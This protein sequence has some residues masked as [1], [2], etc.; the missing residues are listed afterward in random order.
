MINRIF[1]FFSNHLTFNKAEQTHSQNVSAKNILNS[2]IEQYNSYNLI[3]SDSDLSNDHLEFILNDTK[4]ISNVIGTT[5]LNEHLNRLESFIEKKDFKSF[6][7]ELRRFTDI[8]N[9]HKLPLDIQ[10]EFLYFLGIL[11]IEK[12]DLALAEQMEKRLE[13]SNNRFRYNKLRLSIIAAR[14][15]VSAFEKYIAEYE[16]EGHNPE[17]I[18]LDRAF[19]YLN[20]NDFTKVINTLFI[21]SSVIKSLQENEKYNLYLGLAFFYLQEID[22]A[23]TFLNKSYTIKPNSYKQLILL[24]NSLNKI[25]NLKLNRDFINKKHTD[26]LINASNNLFKL[27]SDILS[28]N[29]NV[30]LIYFQYLLTVLLYVN[31]QKVKMVLEEIP[32]EL[33]EYRVFDYYLA[34]MYLIQFDFEKALS[35]Y[36]ILPI[37]YYSPELEEKK[38]YCMY[39]LKQYAKIILEFEDNIVKDFSTHY[40]GIYEIYLRSLYYNSDTEIAER[41]HNLNTP[42]LENWIYYLMLGNLLN[43][44]SYFEGLE[45]L[46]AE[47]DPQT[48]LYIARTFIE[49]KQFDRA[50]EFLKSLE[51]HRIEESLIIEIELALNL[52][53][54]IEELQEYIHILS[55]TSILS[56]SLTKQKLL[57]YLYFDCENYFD[58]TLLLEEIWNNNQQEQN[59]ENA[60]RI[61]IGKLINTDSYS[62]DKYLAVLESSNHPHYL[63]ICAL[64]YKKFKKN[65]LYCFTLL[66]KSLMILDNKFDQIIYED[67]ISLFIPLNGPPICDF[68]NLNE[69]PEK[70]ET[71]CK[72]TLKNST[73]EKIFN[74]YIY[75]NEADIPLL[76]ES[77]DMHI[78]LNSL[79]WLTLRNRKKGELFSFPTDAN[80]FEIIAI[81]NK[82]L[83]LFQYCLASCEKENSSI[84]TFKT[85]ADNITELIEFMKDTLPNPNDYLEL[86]DKYLNGEIPLVV[87]A[88]LNYDKL[89][90]VL[91]LLSN[92]F[93]YKIMAGENNN[94]TTENVVFSISSLILLASK[95][96]IPHLR[97]D[98]HSIYITKSTQVFI[99]RKFN[100]L[101][102]IQEP[103]KTI[104]LNEEGKLCL[105]EGDINEHRK[106]LEL[107]RSLILFTKNPLVKVVQPQKIIEKDLKEFNLDIDPLNLA[108]QLEATYISE[109]F[110]IKRLETTL[111]V[112]NMAG[113]IDLMFV[114][115]QLSYNHYISLLKELNLQ[116]YETFNSTHQLNILTEYLL[117]TR[118]LYYKISP[119][120]S[121]YQQILKLYL[122]RANHLFNKFAILKYLIILIR[123][124]ENKKNALPIISVIFDLLREISF[125]HFGNAKLLVTVMITSFNKSN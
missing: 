76:K 22:Q 56:D 90:A 35:L 45:K 43:D 49:F 31:P 64:A 108:A 5:L 29:L 33:K 115:K 36:S 87:L 51:G 116:M 6:E 24:C 67:Y 110:L 1:K 83:H 60:Y 86:L 112:S 77:N 91:N 39:K 12:Q 53:R 75:N 100:E 62:I 2:K 80:N 98:N 50:F 99:E 104:Y 65:F 4:K 88:R 26:D 34:E 55:N 95:N 28:K 41:V 8:E 14:G 9:F 57:A 25:F 117:L 21:E 23:N 52:K 94:I 125:E 10:S 42:I 107:W 7:N 114:N 113:I 63:R 47:K 40:Y 61:L 81:T 27:K 70:V 58:S 44:P 120:L 101:S 93:K 46:K 19:F 122:K 37:E 13:L 11:Y 59:L 82:Y 105:N 3:L 54:N 124:A 32:D 119:E 96:L 72:V 121:E 16:A 17:D 123:K 111:S 30:Q 66:Y 68:L 69:N 20:T 74:V 15:D 48:S 18:L 71:D 102:G 89:Y 84:T 97:L 109:D 78:S 73:S 118:P 106:E 79:E 38:F 103:V 92:H 85:D